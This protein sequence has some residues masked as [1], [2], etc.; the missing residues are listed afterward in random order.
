MLILVRH[1]MPAHG[2]DVPARDWGLAPEGREATRSLCSRLPAG[3]RLVAS[4]EPKAVGTLEAAGRA[5]E[6]PR[7]DEVV[8]VEAYSD[9]FRTQRLAY[10]EGSDHAEW[11]ARGEV[12]RR[13]GAGVADHLAA[14]DGQPLVIATHGMAMTLW[15]TATIG[16][17]DPGAF[18]ADLRF[19]DAQVVDLAA[20]TVARLGSSA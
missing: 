8:R 6:D 2:P 5:L 4:S 9:D 16:L 18:W 7:F 13:F 1:A 12:V 10:V 11:E 14:A 15:L 20:G 17:G 3:A 19:P